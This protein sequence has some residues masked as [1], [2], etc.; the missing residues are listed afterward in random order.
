[1]DIIQPVALDLAVDR[2]RH[3]I[4]RGQFGALVIVGHEAVPGFG[5]LEDSALAAHRLG[6]Q[7]ILDLQMVQARRVELH[8]FHVADACAGAPRHRDPVPRRP[9]RRGRIKVSSASSASGKDRRPRGQRFNLAIDPVVGVQTMHRAGRA[10]LFGVATG[11]E[12]D[13][14]HVGQDGDVGMRHR[15]FFQRLRDRPAGGVGDM[16]DP[17]VA[18]PALASQMPAVSVV[19]EVER[20]PE[21]GQ[22]RDRRRRSADDMLDHRAVVQARPGD[23]RVLDMRVEAVAF[24]EHRGDPALGPFGRPAA[25]FA[26]G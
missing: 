11:G 19:V 21:I 7:E 15:G 13:R 2:P 6:D 10:E 14:Y 20:H 5:M 16:D 18:V 23:H 9:A 22:P 4:A 1:M 26:L 25:Q 8:E 17:P 3:D 12:V 24:L